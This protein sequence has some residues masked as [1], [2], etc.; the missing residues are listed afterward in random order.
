MFSIVKKYD[1]S[2]L[3]AFM[4][5][6]VQASFKKNISNRVCRHSIAINSS[7]SFLRA[8]KRSIKNVDFNNLLASE[9]SMVLAYVLCFNVLR[10]NCI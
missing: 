3:Q 9:Q 6:S 8:F 5:H 2:Q 1:R 10:C 7:F 4:S